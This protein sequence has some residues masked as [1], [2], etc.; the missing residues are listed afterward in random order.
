[1]DFI[2]FS[3]LL[4]CLV[5]TLTLSYTLSYDICCQWSR[6]AKKWILQLPEA[7]QAAPKILLKKVKY[8][9]LKFHLHNHGLKFHL[10]FNLNFLQYSA[11][12][13]LEDPKHWWA[14]INPISMSMREMMRGLRIDILND[15]A[16][17]WNWRKTTALGEYRCYD[18]HCSLTNQSSQVNG[19]SFSWTRLSSWVWS[20]RRSSMTLT[21]S[22]WLRS[23]GS[24]TWKLVCRMLT[25]PR[26]ILTLSQWPVHI[27][28]WY[29]VIKHANSSSR[30]I[31]GTG[32]VALGSRRGWGHHHWQSH[33]NAQGLTCYLL[34][35]GSQSW[36]TAVSD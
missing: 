1:M 13:D 3:T 26:Q 17:G 30:N 27:P 28:V 15:H 21:S 11:Q 32:L 8:I 2:L 31:H 19:F 29:L 18:C 36:R 4:Y 6:N 10:Q 20:I 5:A 16:T 14:H 24:G 25:V 9:I 7:M 35:A 34:K 33:T 12:S 23:S 22:F